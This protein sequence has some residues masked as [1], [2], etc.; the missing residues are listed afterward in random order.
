M[1]LIDLE[2]LTEL[3][4]EELALQSVAGGNC[5]PYYDPY[6]SNLSDPSLSDSSSS[7]SVFDLAAFYTDPSLVIAQYNNATD[8][9]GSSGFDY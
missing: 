5:D 4:D 1:K 7:T 3:S 8:P 9:Y 6:G 2:F